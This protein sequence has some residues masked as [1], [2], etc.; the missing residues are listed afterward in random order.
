MI[1]KSAARLVVVLFVFLLIPG[2]GF[3]GFQD[4]TVIKAPKRFEVLD[5]EPV[6]IG[7]KF[8]KT[9]QQGSFRA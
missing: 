8:K 3:A 5:Y 4:I 6:D 2:T 1:V 7:I 9:P